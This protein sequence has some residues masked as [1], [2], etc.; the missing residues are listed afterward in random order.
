MFHAFNQNFIP[1]LSHNS[2]KIFDRNKAENGISERR[3][4][5]DNQNQ[6]VECANIHPLL[7]YTAYHLASELKI[8]VKHASKTN[9]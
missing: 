4:G 6:V 5:V 2:H 7:L 8:M 9:I 3:V 1:K